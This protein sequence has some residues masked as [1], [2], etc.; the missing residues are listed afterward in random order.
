MKKIK[1]FLLTMVVVVIAIM[2]SCDNNIF[3]YEN[4]KAEIMNVDSIL[5]NI[6][7]ANYYVNPYDTVGKYHNKI[8]DSCFLAISKS[9]SRGVA[10]CDDNMISKQL[11]QIMERN[12]FSDV[13]LP[14]ISPI[15]IYHSI[16]QDS[17]NESRSN[18]ELDSYIS[19]IYRTIEN[20]KSNTSPQ[21]IIDK[22]NLIEYDISESDLNEVEKSSLLAVLSVSKYSFVYWNK[23]SY[24]RLESKKSRNVE[25]LTRGESYMNQE[26]WM[27]SFRSNFYRV[28]NADI[29]G[30]TQAMLAELANTYFTGPTTV[31]AYVTGITLSAVVR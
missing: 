14:E 20:P 13:Q 24:K 3:L 1:Y 23:E 4:K 29:T 30:G 27:Q 5:N 2:N 25:I 15:E 17:A 8:L 26:M 11:S 19:Q 18:S 10:V 7:Y 28:W 22:L 16:C 31:I 9:Q 6:N 21:D 12:P